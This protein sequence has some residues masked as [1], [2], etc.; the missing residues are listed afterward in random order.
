VIGEIFIAKPTLLF[1]TQSESDVIKDGP[2]S[3][4]HASIKDHFFSWTLIFLTVFI[5]IGD[6]VIVRKIRGAEPFLLLGMFSLASI[7][8]SGL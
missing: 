3:I 8:L 5:T 1:Q 6:F 2:E 4:T 7:V